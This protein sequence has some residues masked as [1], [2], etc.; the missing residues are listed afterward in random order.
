MVHRPRET[1]PPPQRH[2]VVV[3]P[4]KLLVETQYYNET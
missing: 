2:V 1:P 4:S 3:S